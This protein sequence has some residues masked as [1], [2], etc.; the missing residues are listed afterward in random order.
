MYR[1]YRSVKAGHRVAMGR[2]CVAKETTALPAGI[3]RYREGNP[4]LQAGEAHL[5]C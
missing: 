3:A 2:V 4:G 5:L 1:Q